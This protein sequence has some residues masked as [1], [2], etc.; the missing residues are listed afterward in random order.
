MCNPGTTGLREK[1]QD[2]VFQLFQHLPDRKSDHRK[3]VMGN[4][5]CIWIALDQKLLL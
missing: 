1:L 4:G 2:L 5:D 3:K